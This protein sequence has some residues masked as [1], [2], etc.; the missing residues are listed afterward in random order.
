MGKYSGQYLS[1][2]WIVATIIN[3]HLHEATIFV[4]SLVDKSIKNLQ[5]YLFKVH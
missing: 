2:F 3:V 4:Y 5:K 1:L